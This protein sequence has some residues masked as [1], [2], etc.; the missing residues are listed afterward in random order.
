[1]QAARPD[2][3]WWAAAA[4]RPGG[5]L[6]WLDFAGLA[7]V[8][9]LSVVLKLA[10]LTPVGPYIFFD[11][12]LYGLGA[13]ALGGDGVY[14]SGHYPFL[15][16]L[17]LAPQ[18]LLGTGYEG[19]FAANVAA[20]SAL[21]VAGWLL[22]RACGA[23]TGTPA[24]LCLALLPI[25]ASYPT[26]VLSENLFV[27]LFAFAAWYAVRGRFDGRWASFVYGG[28]LCGLF[29]TKYLALPAVPLL[30]AFW[31]YGARQ[32]GA[33]AR[34]AGAAGAFAAAG[35]AL[36]LAC[37]LT[38]A[39]R[40]GIGVG[41]AFG[42]GVVEYRDSSLITPASLRFWLAAYAAVVALACGPALA[43]LL[44]QALLFL[45]APRR[46]PAEGPY[47]RLALLCVLLVG[48][49]FLVCVHHSASM[50]MNYPEPQRVVARYLMHV[51]P[52]VV[53]LGVCGV[54]QGVGRR[55]GLP[56]AIAASLVGA[57]ALWAGWRLL[58]HDA[59]W[60]L[61]PWFAGMPLLAPDTLG[62]RRPGVAV[63]AVATC[64]AS[65]LLAR[66]RFVRGLYVVAL[67]AILASGSLYVGQRARGETAYR[68]VHARML[69]P[70]VLAE[71]QAGKRVLVVNG[72]PR[73]SVDDMRQALIF[74]G[75][76][77]ERLDVVGEDRRSGFPTGVDSAFRIT[78]RTVDGLEE[79]H[80]YRIGT[81]RVTIY[82]DDPDALGALR[83]PPALPGAPVAARVLP[84]CGAAA[85]AAL[86]WSFH[87]D[88][89][90]DVNIYAVDGNGREHLFARDHGA[91][92]RSTG[93]WVAAE[94]RFRFR[95]AES[96]RLLSE[97]GA[98]RSGC[99]P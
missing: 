75:A 93:P 86:E 2:A 20:T 44:E 79:V 53:V 36:L 6:R 12:L 92:S 88:H 78:T 89:P 8:V 84:P 41:D 21:P 77:P 85:V 9:A 81:R 47:A 61:P 7:L 98:D 91:G 76:D 11:E 71:M 58:Y 16:P 97:V 99:G 31:L 29:L 62:F 90:G 10:W 17:Y 87:P 23:R 4:A 43:R 82:R 3:S 40:A 38:V 72:A 65:L 67:A 51:V 46:F 95:S 94:T 19:I 52:L 27:P 69:A 30:A 55:A 5:A 64:A 26:Q 34:E 25:H 15:Y 42:G 66:F 18:F 32:G 59:V 70:Y 14:P 28:L 33:S 35:A 22:A 45:R 37:W 39:T 63:A 49:Y 24:A 50:A 60:T 73:I 68:P 56:L 83:E 48:G 1:M 80:G 96:G 13:R 57:V 74:W 54:G